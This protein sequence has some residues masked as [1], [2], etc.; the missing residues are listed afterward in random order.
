MHRAGIS[1]PWTIAPGDATPTPGSLGAMSLRVPG[2]LLSSSPGS[3]FPP[4]DWSQVEDNAALAC[5]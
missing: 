3:P 1:A 4:I 2:L 5:S